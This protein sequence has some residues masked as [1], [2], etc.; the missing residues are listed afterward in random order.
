MQSLLQAL[1]SALFSLLFIV[2]AFIAYT[3]RAEIETLLRSGL[4]KFIEARRKA[5]TEARAKVRDGEQPEDAVKKL[6]LLTRLIHWISGD[7]LYPVEVKAK[8]ESEKRKG[9]VREPHQPASAPTLAG[10]APAKAAVA[11]E[12]A[13][14]KAKAL[15]ELRQALAT[16]IPA[17]TEAGNTA[18]V[19]PDSQLSSLNPQL[20]APPQP[21]PAPSLAQAKTPDPAPLPL[22]TLNLQLS[23][24]TPQPSTPSS[25][26]PSTLNPQLST[27]SPPPPHPSPKLEA[28]VLELLRTGPLAKAELATRLGQKSPSSALKHTLHDLIER[29]QI[30]YT[31]SEA[32]SSHG[33]KYRLVE[34]S[35]TVAAGPKSS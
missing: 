33:Q 10:A 9:P 27:S 6:G 29:R 3:F 2:P 4:H 21:T 14:I 8:S 34:T 25:P 16:T 15:T 35:K 11:A 24:P 12:V 32:A 26:P 19:A 28:R 13:E 18:P 31:L 7:S 30:E 22:S 1:G 5:A 17:K 23:A 20:S